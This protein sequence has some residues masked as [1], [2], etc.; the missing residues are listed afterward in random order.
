M[1]DPKSMKLIIPMV[2][3]LDVSKS[4]SSFFVDTWQ[5]HFLC[6]SLKYSGEEL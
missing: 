4:Y 6:H 2:S 5:V 1:Y 3:C